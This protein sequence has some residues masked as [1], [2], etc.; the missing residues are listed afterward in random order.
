MRDDVK[1]LGIVLRRTNY[2][3]ADRILNIITPEGKISA[4][5]KGVRKAR[6]KLAGGVEM[7]SLSD[8]VI[9]RGRGE[10]GVVTSARMVR[11]YDKLLSDYERMELAVM[12]LKKISLAAEGSDNADFFRL[13]QESLE[14]MNDGYN[15]EL[16]EGWFLLNL[17]RASGEEV[18]VYR[19]ESGVK[20][21]AGAKYKWDAMEKAFVKW[22]AGE[23]GVDEIKLL[24]LMLSAKLAVVARVKGVLGL[25]PPALTVAR[26]YNI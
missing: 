6:S 23:Y 18:N 21:E 16:V 4:M 14:G 7:F 10:L 17:V 8:Y 12:I 26:S 25:V 11:Y 3:E 22:E 24:R 19:D 1:T 2:G 15:A 5:A 9:H 13:A 20:L